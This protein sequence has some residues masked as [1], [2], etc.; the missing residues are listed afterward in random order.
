MSNFLKWTVELSISKVWVEDGF[1]LTEDELINM[2]QKRLPYAFS[3]EVD[4][5]IIKAPKQETINKLQGRIE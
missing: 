1:T 2:L 4:A 3:H 5:K